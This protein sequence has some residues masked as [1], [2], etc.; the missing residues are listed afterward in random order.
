MP[1]LPEHPRFKGITLPPS[2][3]ALGVLLSLYI[4][5]GLIGHD[6]W[7]TDDA[8][9]IG[10][11]H[12]MLTSGHWLMPHLAGQ[13]YPDAPLYYW[14]AAGFGKLFSW[15][16]QE[17]EAARL[18][19]GLFTLLALEFIL[20]AA[21]E[22]HG[23]DYAAAAP[24]ILAGSI[25]FLFHAHEAQPMLAALT[26]HTAAY[27]AL[28]L[29]PRRPGL[30]SAVYG[31]SV[32]LGF[33]ANG[34]LPVLTLLP[35]TLIA[36]WQS[37]DRKRSSLF[38]ALAM[39]LA[40]LLCALWL[41][42]LQMAAP[43]YLADFLR[44]ELD[45]LILSVQPFANSL[46]YL[47]LLL[48]YAW[49]ALPLAAWALWSKR[50]ILS[51]RPLMLPILSFLSVLLMLGLSVK[52]H[53][54]PALLLLPPLVLL[55]VPGV[56]TLRRGAAN[57]FDWFGMMVFSIFATLAWIVWSAMVFGWPERLA[58]QAV[59]LEPGFVGHFSLIA[60]AFSVLGTVIW[61]WLIV[62]SPRSP[63]RGIMHWMAGLTLFWLLIAAL[64]MPWIDYGKTYRPLSASL[65]KALPAKV[66]CITNANLPDAILATLDYFN[67][68]RT[69]PLKNAKGERCNWL[70]VQGEFHDP[71]AI[72]AAGWRR[73]WE[74]RRPG[75]RRES[76]LFHL[77][78]RENRARSAA[79]LHDMLVESPDDGTTRP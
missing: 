51:T 38:L 24:L 55:A 41:I 56:A 20:L 70:L 22:L 40:L 68:I 47:N 66:G 30:A 79:S 13:P 64:W 69:V 29:L 26:A 21:R 61:F 48:W 2:G 33:L 59:R 9:S 52:L 16:L 31:A 74:S 27:W 4:F 10:I 7:K 18:A 44:G 46:R 28:T 14:V 39:F 50:R 72:A 3:W 42:P 6:P 43:H 75:D 53:S 35:V 60:C 54:A 34:L 25:G 15:L 32:A 36:L 45:P 12:D 77:Y 49:P 65:A 1:F 17:H 23:K 78:R 73:V 71:S 62:T 76:E 5:T 19:S 58:R 67:G 63:M 37:G 57:A 8:I 11:A